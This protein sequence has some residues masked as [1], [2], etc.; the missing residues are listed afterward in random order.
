M[1]PKTD[2]IEQAERPL[3][4]AEA[5]LKAYV[6]ATHLRTSVLSTSRPG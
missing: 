5:E 2:E 6:E 1:K 4:Q 3:D